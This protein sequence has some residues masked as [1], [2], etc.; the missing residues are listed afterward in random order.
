MK[1]KGIMNVLYRPA[2]E[3]EHIL[4]AS[5][6]AGNPLDLMTPESVLEIRRFREAESRHFLRAIPSLEVRDVSLPVPGRGIP[7]RIYRPLTAK[8]AERMP[9]LVFMHGGGWTLGSLQ[10]HDNIA[11]AL[12]AKTP[13]IVVA[14]DYRLAPEHPFPAGIEDAFA[15]L[16][17]VSLNARALGGDPAR[18]GLAGDSA[19]A[20]IA[21]VIARRARR[22]G[23]PL[24]YQA[25]FYPSTDLSHFESSS[26]A[27]FGRGYLLTNESLRRFRDFYLRDERDWTHPEASPLLADD[28]EFAGL[29]PSLVLV[30]GCDPLRD[31]GIAFARKLDA[32]GVPVK[33]QVMENMIHGFLRFYNTDSKA[34]ALVESILDGIA[35]DVR[36]GFQLAVEA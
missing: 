26:H 11:K 12:A 30:A 36:E 2:P 7:L 19:G 16:E 29:P 22:A 18:I 5:E 6:A 10:T 27:E 23:L 9:I 31:E 21:T 8:R 1:V 33:L 28:E 3:F 14:V 13:A 25:L 34:T 4:R 15:A 17:W 20:N 24:A 32:S 35:C